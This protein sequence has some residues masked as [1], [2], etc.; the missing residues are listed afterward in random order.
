MYTKN[1]K[2]KVAAILG[3][4]ASAFALFTA[5]NGIFSIAVMEN[6]FIV[7]DEMMNMVIDPETLMTYLDMIEQLGIL[8]SMNLEQWFI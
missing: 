5:I 4:I 2:Y 6:F 8:Q 1:N 7:F 3:L